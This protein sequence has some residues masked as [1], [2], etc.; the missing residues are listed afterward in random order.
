MEEAT[1][2]TATSPVHEVGVLLL[3]KGHIHIATVD[4]S[5]MHIIIVQH[6]TNIVTHATKKDISNHHQYVKRENKN[7]EGHIGGIHAVRDREVKVAKTGLLE[8]IT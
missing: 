3:T 5:T 4:V 8:S 6:T 1:E 2:G 7:S